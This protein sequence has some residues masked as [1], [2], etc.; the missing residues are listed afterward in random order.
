M[1]LG[2]S[3]TLLKEKYSLYSNKEVRDL[4]KIS[5]Y[6]DVVLGYILVLIL[7][8]SYQRMVLNIFKHLLCWSQFICYVSANWLL[9]SHFCR[10]ANWGPM[11]WKNITMFMHV[12]SGTEVS[13][14]KA[15]LFLFIS[16]NQGTEGWK[17]PVQ[18]L[19]LLRSSEHFCFDVLIILLPSSGGAWQNGNVTPEQA[20]KSSNKSH[21]VLGFI[22]LFGGWGWLRSVQPQQL[23]WLL[24]RTNRH[25]YWFSW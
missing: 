20:P 10:P 22:F 8:E 16:Q 21:A 3:L 19:A 13:R 15:A 4:A 6:L 12:V 23:A 7:F 18:S 17:L 11:S 25:L 1:L 2:G 14:P 9:L 24:L 5:K